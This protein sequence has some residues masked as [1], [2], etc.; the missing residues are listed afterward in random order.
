MIITHFFLFYIYPV[1][2]H[3][4]TYRIIKRISQSKSRMY[5]NFWT[6]FITDLPLILSQSEINDRFTIA[7]LILDNLIPMSLPSP[8]WTLSTPP[9]PVPPSPLR[10]REDHSQ[11]FTRAVEN[12]SNSLHLARSLAFSDHQEGPGRDSAA[13]G[14]EPTVRDRR[15]TTGI[16][17]TACCLAS[18]NHEERRSSDNDIQRDFRE[19]ETVGDQGDWREVEKQ[20]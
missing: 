20:R 4:S 11:L 19:Q 16:R 13:F 1:R 18:L 6:L 3:C 8:L 2:N 7:I 12:T 5:I 15:E 17:E 10:G 9:P 14:D